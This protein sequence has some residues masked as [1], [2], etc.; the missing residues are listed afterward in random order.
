[1]GRS[2]SQLP[3]LYLSFPETSQS[4]QPTPGH[5]N[6]PRLGELW[7]TTSLREQRRGEEH[8]TL[9]H[10]QGLSELRRGGPDIRRQSQRAD[11]GTRKPRMALVF[12]QLEEAGPLSLLPL[13]SRSAEAR[14]LT[15]AR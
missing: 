5:R 9:I 2:R 8:E 15:V 12:N 13:L 1:M 3:D 6:M 4:A 7:D 14:D 10:R 11:L